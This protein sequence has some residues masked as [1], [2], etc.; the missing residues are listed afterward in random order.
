[1]TIRCRSKVSPAKFVRTSSR[2]WIVLPD[3]YRLG[4]DDVVLDPPGHRDHLLDPP[5]AVAERAGLTW[6]T[7]LGLGV[8]VGLLLVRLAPTH[9]PGPSRCVR[10]GEGL[11]AYC[12]HQNQQGPTTVNY[13]PRQNRRS[14]AIFRQ[15]PTMANHAGQVPL[16]RLK[17]PCCRR[18]RA[19]TLR[20]GH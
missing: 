19:C 20:V 10:A 11:P 17:P 6:G 3:E 16:H 13:C 15:Q 4:L 9:V 5:G 18:S 1:M 12:P 8:G 2:A 14:E 7:V